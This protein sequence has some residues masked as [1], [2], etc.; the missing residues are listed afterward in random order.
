MGGE[1]RGEA[2]VISGFRFHLAVV[3]GG[4]MDEGR[5]GLWE[6]CEDKEQRGSPVVSLTTPK[7]I[8]LVLLS[9]FLSA[10]LMI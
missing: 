2:G 6:R 8:F 4:G 9:P 1:E 5:W 10:L 7:C 3:A